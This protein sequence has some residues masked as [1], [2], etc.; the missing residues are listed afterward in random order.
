MSARGGIAKSRR[1]G[2]AERLEG[3]PSFLPDSAEVAGTRPGIEIGRLCHGVPGGRGRKQGP[4]K[5]GDI[6]RAFLMGSAWGLIVVSATGCQAPQRSTPEGIKGIEFTSIRRQLEMTARVRDEEQKSKVGAGSSSL[7]EKIFEEGVRLETEGSVYHPNFM[8]FSLAGLFGLLQ[9]DF[10]SSFGDRTR[11]SSD[12]GTILEFDFEGD[13]LKKKPYPGTAYARQYRRLDPRPFLSSLLTT[14]QNYGFAWQY[15]DDQTPTSLQFDSTDVKLDPLDPDEALGRQQNTTLRFETSYRFD[16]HNVLSFTYD[17]R[18]VS[19]QPFDLAY[20]SDEL[21]LGHRLDFGANHRHR[22]DS[23]VVYFD[24]RGTFN[25]ERLRWRETMRLTH[26]E[27]LRS[28]YQ[29][30]IVDRTQGSLSG[31][32]PI[33]ETSYLLSG[34]VEHKLYESLISQLFAFGQF[35][36]FDNGLEITRLGIQPSLDYRKKN[37]WGILLAN[38]QFR[39]QTEDRQG[40]GQGFEVI[41]ERIT[42]NDPDPA[43]LSNS[44]VAISSIFITAEDRA[45]L[46][47]AGEDYRVTRVGDRIEIERVPTGRIAD[48][49]TVEVD[50]TWEISGDLTLDTTTHNFQIRQNF[51]MGL[52]PYY[53][54]RKQDQ[55]ITPADAT[56]VVPEDITAHIVGSEFRRGPVRL[57]AEYEDHDS[58]INPYEAIRLSG[59]FTQRVGRDGTARL[60]TRWVNI[61]RTGD[62]ARRT[63]FFTIEGRHRQRVGKYLTLEGAVLYR[64]EDDSLSGPDEGVDVDLSLEWLIR[65]TELRVTYEYGRFEDDFAENRNQMLY[66]QFRRRF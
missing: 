13:F 41:N 35:Q 10:E 44:N 54:L 38:Y 14:T 27:T 26:S 43:V 29:F 4:P 56:G 66:V 55:E 34:T 3:T 62:I 23:E 32:P 65:E 64:T 17:R 60:R 40:A 20:D 15:V 8:E 2:I 59:D 48:G 7:K 22:L 51:D 31:I 21:K 50:Y 45:T 24:Q 18:T 33:Q 57:L 1:A 36:D 9:E 37:P 49:Q 16:D 39:F 61:D 5:I 53:R 52:Q 12:T 11:A 28:W 19:E 6:L 46:Y 47:R 30:E 58:T 25:I 63:E 42:F